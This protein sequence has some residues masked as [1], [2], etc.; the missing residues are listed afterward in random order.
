[1]G[2]PDLWKYCTAEHCREM[3]LSLGLLEGEEWTDDRV[4]SCLYAVSNHA[5]IHYNKMQIPKKGGGVRTILAPDPLLKAIQRN[6]L[7][8][9]LDG[10]EL[11]PCAAAYHKGASIRRNAAVHVG[12]ETVLKLDI[13]DFFGSITFPMVRQ[14]AFKSRYFPVPVG[15]LLTAL[16]CYKDRLPQGSPA[17][18]AISNLVMKPFDEYMDHWCGEREITYSRYCDD[19]TFSG[20]FDAAEVYGKVKGFL[21]SMGFALN[22]SKTKL[23]T[24]HGRQTVTGMVVNDKI[25][26]PASYRKAVRQE[27][28]YCLKYGVK[29]HLKYRNERTYLDMGE[30]GEQTYLMSLLGK[31]SFILSA[32]PDDRWFKQAAE[33]VKGNLKTYVK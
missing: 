2:G 10:L 16:C 29:E 17:S 5:E 8:H 28:H 13:E 30:K 23:L 7:H 22:A 6:I 24:R 3:L 31:I 18:A 1:M 12:K 27:V 21:T 20:T 19:M 14:S 33:A 32:N 11:S 26:V 4:L 25:Q 9:V 15:T